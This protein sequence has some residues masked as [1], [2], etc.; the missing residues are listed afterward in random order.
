MEGM[1]TLK[2]AFSATLDAIPRPLFKAHDHRLSR[3]KDAY[4]H[5]K[6]IPRV[7]PG[8]RNSVTWDQSRASPWCPVENPT[9]LP[10][11]CREAPP[12]PYFKSTLSLFRSM[13]V[14]GP[15]FGRSWLFCWA[16]GLRDLHQKDFLAP[17]AQG[18]PKQ[19]GNLA[20]LGVC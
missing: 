17:I 6:G 15:S 19:K 16:S 20:M 9:G 10:S 1:V 8:F 13:R 4:T 14:A 3:L 18:Q 11:S 12:A 5:L 2:L 7:V